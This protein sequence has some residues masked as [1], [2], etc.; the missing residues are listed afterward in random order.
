MQV[1]CREKDEMIVCAG[2][3]LSRALRLD[4]AGVTHALVAR[5]NSSPA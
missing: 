3:W 4:Q 1:F 5:G 2:A